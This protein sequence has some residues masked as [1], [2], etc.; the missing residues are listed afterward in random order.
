MDTFRIA[1][2]VVASAIALSACAPA[3]PPPADTTAD[4]ASI[5]AGS[6]AWA[7]AYNAG[8]VDRIVALY[9]ED[10]VM[11]PP[12]VPAASGHAAMRAYLTTDVAAAKAGGV[13]MNLGESG[14]GVSGD[15]GWHSGTF[16]AT[17]AAGT[18][19]DSGKWVETWRKTNGEWRMIRDIWNSDAAP[20]PAAAPAK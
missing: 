5:R 3:A 4:M 18:T 12:N 1:T 8:D 17:T 11:M 2:V 9:A 10:A 13:T 16:A 14:I 15:L 7:D 20:A 19:V 6:K